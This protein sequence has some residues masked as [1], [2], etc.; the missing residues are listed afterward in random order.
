MKWRKV[1]EGLGQ[2]YKVKI[3]DIASVESDEEKKEHYKTVRENSKR[4]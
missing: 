2:Q 4:P 1:R 3:N